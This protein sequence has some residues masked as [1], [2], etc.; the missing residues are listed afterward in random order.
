MITT[1]LDLYKKL[2][3]RHF[4]VLQKIEIVDY[5]WG[6]TL[7]WT[8][9]LEEDRFYK[10]LN[11]LIAYYNDLMFKDID[12]VGRPLSDYDI[13]L[14]RSLEDFRTQR[15]EELKANT[16]LTETTEVAA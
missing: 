11:K 8:P 7:D 15:L 3:A 2:K 5:V 13:E 14:A 16:P 9:S 12:K 6:R 1:E 10:Y 4:G